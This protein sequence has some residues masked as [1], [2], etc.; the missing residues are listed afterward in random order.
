VTELVTH[1][2]KTTVHELKFTQELSL[3]FASF[4]DGTNSSILD[5][6]STLGLQREQGIVCRHDHDFIV[7]QEQRQGAPTVDPRILDFVDE[8]NRTAT[9]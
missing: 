3:A 6:D 9:E 5:D 2:L 8:H 7:G 1:G 4:E